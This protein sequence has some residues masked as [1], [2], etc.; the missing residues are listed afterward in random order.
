MTARN[1]WRLRWLPSGSIETVS[2]EARA[3][4]VV[5]E[6]RARVQSGDSEIT[7]VSVQLD[8]GDGHGWQPY[9]RVT[10]ARPGGAS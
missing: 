9:A 4:E 5:A 2:S 6:E 3:Y 1:K 8:T 7:G 10:F